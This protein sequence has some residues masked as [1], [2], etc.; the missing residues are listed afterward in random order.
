MTAPTVILP[1]TEE[2]HAARAQG[3]GGTDI[4]AVAGLNPWRT[5]FDVYCEKRGLTERQPENEAMKM[6]KRLE[7]VVLDLYEEATGYQ[8]EP[9]LFTVHPSLPWACGTPDALTLA[10]EGPLV[11]IKTAG[12]RQASRWGEPGTDQIPDHYLLQVQWYLTLTKRQAAD[13]AVLLGGQEFRLYHLAH[14]QALEDRLL[15][16][17]EKFWK[18]NVLAGNPPEIGGGESAKRWLQQTFPKDTRPEL[19]TAPPVLDEVAS[20]LDHEISE[21]DRLEAQ[22][23][24]HRNIIKQHIADAA[25][26]EGFKWRATWKASKDTAVTDWAKVAWYLSQDNPA[27]LEIAKQKFTNNKPGSRRFLFKLNKED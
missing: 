19:L 6:G 27:A 7:P 15:E 23:E 26:V 4:S 25:G 24:V 13:I 3:L 22:A 10:P 2:W 8:T 18:E 5:P 21:I 20:L 17:G 9:G 11:E 16:I 1:G 14:N 12:A